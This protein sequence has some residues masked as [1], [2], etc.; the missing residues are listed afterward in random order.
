M[1]TGN[2]IISTATLPRPLFQVGQLSVT[3]ERMCIDGSSLRRSIRRAILIFGYE[4]FTCS[5]V[6]FNC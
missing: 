5:G 3:G 6:F 2:E 1:E 4:V